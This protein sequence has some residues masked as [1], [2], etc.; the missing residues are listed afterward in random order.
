M[1]M[2]SE[3]LAF[4]NRLVKEVQDEVAHHRAPVNSAVGGVTKRHEMARIEALGNS[5]SAAIQWAQEA[6]ELKRIGDRIQ[7]GRD[8]ALAAINAE[9]A[10]KRQEEYLRKTTPSL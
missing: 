2:D 4:M 5:T 9:Q 3:S 7:Q 8:E 10:R 6:A 1:F